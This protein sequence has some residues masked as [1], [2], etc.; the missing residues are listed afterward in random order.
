M[1]HVGVLLNPRKTHGTVSALE[2]GSEI[3]LAFEIQSLVTQLMMD[4]SWKFA[5]TTKFGFEG[6][7]AEFFA[8]DCEK[9]SFVVTKVAQNLLYNGDLSARLQQEC[10]KNIA[11]NKFYLQN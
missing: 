3:G 6:V 2:T 11:I 8:W 1:H 10:L 5:A 4:Q 7:S 9:L